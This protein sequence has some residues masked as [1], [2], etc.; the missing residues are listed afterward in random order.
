[1]N[2]PAPTKAELLKSGWRVEQ[3]YPTGS[4]AETKR[5]PWIVQRTDGPILDRFAT[6]AEALARVEELRA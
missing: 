3:Y 6:R 5:R 1:M 2:T 4:D